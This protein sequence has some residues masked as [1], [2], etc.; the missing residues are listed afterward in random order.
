MARPRA[1]GG[2]RNPDAKETA[3]RCACRHTGA[4]IACGIYRDAVACYRGPWTSGERRGFL[5]DGDEII[6]R[7]TAEA[8]GFVPIGFGECRAVILPAR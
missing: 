4:G 2:K 8:D 6:M 1:S 7:A 3:T 5:E